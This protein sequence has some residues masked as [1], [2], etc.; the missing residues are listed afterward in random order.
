VSGKGNGIDGGSGWA[1][2]SVSSGMVASSRYLI[3]IQYQ[4]SENDCQAAPLFDGRKHHQ[5]D[6]A[7][8][9]ETREKRGSVEWRRNF[10]DL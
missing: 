6:A 4:I 1:E 5:D 2:I 9:T 8:L 3:F 7:N 10:F